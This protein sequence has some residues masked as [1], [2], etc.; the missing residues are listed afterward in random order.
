VNKERRETNDIMNLSSMEF[1]KDY[2]EAI[3][4]SLPLEDIFKVVDSCHYNYD[5]LYAPMLLKLGQY[6]DMKLNP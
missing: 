5:E 3:R 6:C 2:L 4:I 1:G